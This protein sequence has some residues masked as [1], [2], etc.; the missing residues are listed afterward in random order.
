M[1]KANG[2]MWPGLK[3]GFACLRQIDPYHFRLAGWQWDGGAGSLVSVVF[4]VDITFG[5]TA[6][7]FGK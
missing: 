3:M 7:G 2:S 5:R 6:N 4:Q 1:K